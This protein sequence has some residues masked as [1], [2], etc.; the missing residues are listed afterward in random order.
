MSMG[1]SILL[2]ISDGD[3]IARRLIKLA[4]NILPIK[5][6]CKFD[7]AEYGPTSIL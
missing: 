7:K 4:E 6:R 1:V 3:L 2:L 5:F